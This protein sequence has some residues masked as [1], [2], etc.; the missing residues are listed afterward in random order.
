MRFG[1]RSAVPAFAQAL[2][3]SGLR[4]P[5]GKTPPTLAARQV[6]D[7]T[8]VFLP[9]LAA[10]HVDHVFAGWYPQDRRLTVTLVVD[11]SWSMSDPGSPALASR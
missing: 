9:V 10:H 11:V 8:G 2:D 5:D 7:L 6:P 4:G 3:A 1:P